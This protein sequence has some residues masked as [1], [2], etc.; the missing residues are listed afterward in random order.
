MDPVN[1]YRLRISRQG[2]KEKKEETEAKLEERSDLDQ[3]R[4][5][6]RNIRNAKCDHPERFSLRFN[7]IQLI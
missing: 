7:S 5:Q 3:P 1:G 2:R 6:P 4:G